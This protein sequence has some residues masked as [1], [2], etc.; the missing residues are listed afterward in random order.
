M[1][2]EDLFARVYPGRTPYNY[3]KVLAEGETLPALLEAPTGAG[4][5]A[6]VLGAWIYRR[7]F[8]PSNVI[9]G[10]TPRRLAYCLPMRAL[11]EQTHAEAILWLEKLGLLAGQKGG[12]VEGSAA[13]R[14]GNDPGVSV[15]LLMGGEDIGDWDLYPECEAILVGTQDMLL[16]RALNRGYASGRSRWPIEFGLINNDCLWVMDE[17]QLMGS[18]LTT[19]AELRRSCR[20]GGSQPAWGTSG[21]VSSYG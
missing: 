10:S 12:A 21:R 14:D 16:S 3:Q 18:G 20:E 15:R 13:Q 19:T 6:A 4:K 1:D 11:V 9:R 7:R 17:V 2:Y 8:H 5:T